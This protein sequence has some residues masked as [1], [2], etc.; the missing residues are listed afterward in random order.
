MRKSTIK[1]VNAMNKLTKYAL[2][3]AMC[4]LGLRTGVMLAGGGQGGDPGFLWA[5]TG[6]WNCSKGGIVDGI[7]TVTDQPC[8]CDLSS[9]AAAVPTCTYTGNPE[10][11]C[12]EDAVTSYC[13]GDNNDGSG[14]ACEA[15]YEACS[16]K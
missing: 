16:L 14:N 13:Q 12:V 6:L 10:D 3:A 15:G 11:Y 5:C 2:C 9:S 8:N 4:M 7:D 1:G